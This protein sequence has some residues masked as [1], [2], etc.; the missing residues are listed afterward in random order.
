MTWRTTLRT[1]FTNWEKLADFLEL[2]AAARS[3]ILKK[4]SFPLNLPRRLAEKCKKGS[5]DDPILKQFLPDCAEEEGESGFHLDPVSDVSFQKSSKALQKY[6]GRLLLVT[7]S[8]CAMHCRYC[9]RQNYPYEMERREFSEELQLLRSDSSIEE[10]LLSGG[11]PLSLPNERL[12]PL[13][14]EIDEVE[15]VKRIRFHSRFIVGIPERVDEPFLAQLR[16]LRAACFFV[17][18]INHPREIDRE[19]KEALAL[20]KASGVQLLNQSVLLRG[21]NDEVKTQVELS[22]ELIHAG[23]LPYYLHALDLVK[24]SKRFY[25]SDEEGKKLILEMQKRLPGYAVPRFVREIPGESS[26]TLL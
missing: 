8:A 18:H 12:L 20:L 6:E 23:V 5:I 17:V 21:V 14:K 19:V 10:V 2:S 1:N 7:T 25:V 15:H 3:T 4:S 9:F 26:K 24:G 22:K 13:L 11:D 16:A